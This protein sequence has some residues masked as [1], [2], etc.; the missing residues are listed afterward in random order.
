MHFRL[1][2]IRQTYE[3]SVIQLTDNAFC[4]LPVQNRFSE[5]TF[6]GCHPVTKMKTLSLG[7]GQ[8]DI[9]SAD[10]SSNMA[11]KWIWFDAKLIPAQ[12]TEVY[13]YYFCTVQF[14]CCYGHIQQLLDVAIHGRV[15]LDHLSNLRWS[16]IRSAVTEPQGTNWQTITFLPW[17]IY[18]RGRTNPSV[19]PTVDTHR[20][21]S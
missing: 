6:Y 7:R 14:M 2:Q 19:G 18:F 21:I 9:V 4:A 16:F 11:P 15:T 1:L 10:I 12:D 8:K 5:Y 13:L 17:T 3:Q 20:W